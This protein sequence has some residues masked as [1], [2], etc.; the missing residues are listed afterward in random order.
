MNGSRPTLD[1]RIARPERL[2]RDEVVAAV[3]TAI[4]DGAL[5]PGRRITERELT[6]LTGVSRTSVREA[7]RQLQAQGLL[8][9]AESGGLRVP[10]LSSQDVEHFY[11]VRGAL[12][13]M[14]IECFT[15]RASNEEIQSLREIIET[16]GES[17]PAR[18]KAIVKFDETI[19]AGCRN[20]VLREMLSSLYMRIHALRRLS[21]SIPDR[22]SASWA[23]YRAIVEAVE[24]RSP[25]RASAAARSHIAQAQASALKAMQILEE[26]GAA[27][28]PKR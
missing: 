5:V 16:A 21:L 4:L 9:A 27:G 13:P 6:D 25:E 3:R 26:T 14:A 1:M 15:R 8:E 12:E 10:T 24:E 23:E 7:L 20:P 28:Q 19:Q 18:L 2:V 17:Q 11:E 22:L